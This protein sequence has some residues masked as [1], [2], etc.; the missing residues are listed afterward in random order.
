M[1]RVLVTPRALGLVADRLTALGVEAVVL[2][3]V[4]GSVSAR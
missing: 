3:P 2:A 1:T 4:D